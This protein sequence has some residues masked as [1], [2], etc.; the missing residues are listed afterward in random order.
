MPRKRIVY[1]PAIILG[2]IIVATGIYTLAA[3]AWDVPRTLHYQGRLFDGEGSPVEGPRD[4]TFRIWD[5]ATETGAEHLLWQDELRVTFEEG[6]YFS[7]ELG[8]TPDNGFP[9]DLFEASERWLGVEVGTSGELSPRHVLNAVPYAIKAGKSAAIAEGTDLDDGMIGGSRVSDIIAALEAR[10]EVLETPEP[11]ACPDHA[12]EMVMVGDFCIDKYEIS[13]W[14]NSDCDGTGIKYGDSDGDWPAGFPKNGN[15]TSEL[16]ACSISDA[17][18][19]RYMTWF[20]AV[21]AC[22]LSQKHLCTNAQWQAAVAGTP[23]DGS[24]NTSSGGPWNTGHGTC[25]SSYGAEDMIGNLWEWTTLWTQAGPTAGVGDGQ[26]RC[27]WPSGY[28]DDCTWNLDGRANNGTGYVGGVPAA[29]LRGGDFHYG[30]KAGAFALD[31]SFGPRTG[32]TSPQAPGAA[33]K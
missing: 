24:C 9:E 19:S 20:Q 6:G 29:A 7:V 2:L 18:P 3:P 22:A 12:G 11:P 28:N 10:I 30:T 17:A 1:F 15:W 33:P 13:L 14:D 25:A 26:D 5:D 23:D 31:L 16:Y 4:V 21:Q 27:N 32:A 8:V